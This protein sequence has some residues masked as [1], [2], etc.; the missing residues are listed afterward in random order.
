MNITLKPDDERIGKIINEQVN[1]PAVD[2]AGQPFQRTAISTFSLPAP[3]GE[4]WFVVFPSRLDDG[5]IIITLEADKKP[6]GKPE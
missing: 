4:F 3:A 5:N 2:I 1:W 6:K